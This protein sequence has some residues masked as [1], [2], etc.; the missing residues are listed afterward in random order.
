M[1]QVRSLA[2]D[3]SF[4]LDKEVEVV[5]MLKLNFCE[6]YDEDDFKN[7]KE[8]YQDDFYPYDFEGT[9][10]GTAIEMKSRRVKKY[11]YDTTILPVHKVRKTDKTQLFIFN[12]TDNC[13]YIKYDEALFKT[14]KQK[15][16]TTER[17][18]SID[19]PKPHYLIPVRLLTD[20]IN[21]YTA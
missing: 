16:I 1:S 3:L 6:L 5:D 18:G 14:F 4:G 10:N 13:S 8:L 20:L 7:T 12:F 19:R 15:D 21:V 17:F 9:T 2:N 11:Y